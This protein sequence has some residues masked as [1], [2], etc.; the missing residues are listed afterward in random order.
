MRAVEVAVTKAI[1]LARRSNLAIF[2]YISEHPGI[3]EGLEKI[4]C[5]D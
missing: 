2:G 4:E 1:R 3:R 5:V